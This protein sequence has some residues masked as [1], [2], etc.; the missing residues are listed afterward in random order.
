MDHHIVK[1]SLQLGRGSLL[2][3]ED[4]REM[5]LYARSGALWVTQAGDPRDRYLHAGDWFT[6]SSPGLTLVSALRGSSIALAS[7]H[8]VGFAERIDVVRA[9]TGQVEPI[10]TPAPGFSGWVATMR[11]RMA[12]AWTS[13]FAARIRVT[14]ASL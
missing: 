3:I 5:V 1:S 2:R 9:S 11:A 10:F 8:A 13:A 14:S 7:P 12:K 4:G 6:I